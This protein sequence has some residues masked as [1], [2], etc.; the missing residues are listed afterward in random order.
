MN[1]LKEKATKIYN[2]FCNKIIENNLK[3]AKEDD[4][5]RVSFSAMGKDDPMNFRIMIEE[6]SQ[7]IKIRSYIPISIPD[8]KKDVVA[9]ALCVVNSRITDGNFDYDSQQKMVFFRITNSFKDV[10]IDEDIVEYL[11]NYSLFIVDKF[12][13]VIK[14]FS[15]GI[16]SFEELL[17][18]VYK[19]TTEAEKQEMEN[20]VF[21]K[22]TSKD[23]EVQKKKLAE[24]VFEFIKSFLKENDFDVQPT[25]ILE[26]GFKVVGEDLEIP[27]I[28]GV[29]YKRSLIK[30]R[31]PLNFG[32][33]E[34]KSKECA[35]F[36]CHIN[37]GM[38][39][40]CFEY[41]Y[42]HKRVAFRTEIFYSKDKISEE[43]IGYMLK[44]ALEIVDKY[45][46]Y[47]LKFI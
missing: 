4:K 30:F 46:Q 7:L 44:E 10:D 8:E 27:V 31:S 39:D 41:D 1:V 35:F 34:S 43:L 33:D 38:S 5:L 9:I 17:D 12:D 28:I 3:T 11:L 6:K 25:D 16:M 47:F 29:D 26:L 13:T 23:K 2:I 32:I 15:A 45:N 20:K 14:T 22:K 18:I 24:E 37:F 36:V 21:K 42:I 40:G 19:P